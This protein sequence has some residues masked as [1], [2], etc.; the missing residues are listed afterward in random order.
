[1]NWDWEHVRDKHPEETFILSNIEDII[2]RVKQGRIHPNEAL[3][4]IETALDKKYTDS[5][6]SRKLKRVYEDD[7]WTIDEGNGNLRITLFKDGHYVEEVSLT[8]E[9]MQSKLL[10]ILR[11]LPSE[12]WEVK[13]YG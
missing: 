9:I 5:S 4:I 13:C 6:N 1:M 10:D 7:I 8:P 11:M 3:R 12:M 2:I